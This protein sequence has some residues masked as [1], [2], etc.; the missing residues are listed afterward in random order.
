LGQAWLGLQLSFECFV[1]D[2]GQHGIQLGGGLGLH[3]DWCCHDLD[4][5]SERSSFVAIGHL[6]QLRPDGDDAKA[7][8][9]VPPLG[10]IGRAAHSEPAWRAPAKLHPTDLALLAGLCTEERVCG[11]RLA[12][13]RRRD[14]CVGT[15][16]TTRQ[17]CDQQKT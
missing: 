3:P 5:W 2:G 16:L 15:V 4:R 7:D 9:V 17:T 14:A 11:G 6:G 1:Q 12:D 10:F 13:V 8:V